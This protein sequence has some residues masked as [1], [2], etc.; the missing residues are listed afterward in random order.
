MKRS[1]PVLRSTTS[2]GFTLIELLVVIAIIAVLIALLLPAVQQAR[3]AARRSQCKNNLKQL[4][5]ATHNFHDN[6]NQF[7]PECLAMDSNCT[8]GAWASNPQISTFAMILPFMDQAPAYNKLDVWKGAEAHRMGALGA[9][10]Y[11]NG[12]DTNP[13]VVANHWSNL[14]NSWDVAVAKLEALT[15]P[16]DVMEGQQQFSEFI[17]LH[18]YCNDSGTAGA[19]CVSTGGGGTIGGVTTL[20]DYGFGRTSYLPVGGAIG[21]LDNLWGKWSGVFGGWTRVKM[22]NITDGTSNT[23]LFG[24]AT[25]GKDYNYLWIST[26]AMPTAWN[27]GKNWYQF[28]SEHVGGT[29]FALADGSVRFLSQNMDTLNYRRVSAVADSEVVGE[30]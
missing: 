19:R 26:G 18:G 22:S 1:V 20:K 27:F 17:V 11:C 9:A 4:A 5:L 10:A 15:C 13:A 30:F 7:P 21:R 24:E 23:I 8:A 16:S 28:S 29:H 3:E 12:Y 25:G 14:Q 6:Y 2:R